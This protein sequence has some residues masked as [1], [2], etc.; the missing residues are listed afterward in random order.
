M[1]D[2][3]FVLVHDACPEAV[4]DV[5]GQC[6]DGPLVLVQRHREIALV[7]QP[8]LLVELLF[9]GCCLVCPVVFQCR[10]A[11]PSAP[12]ETGQGRPSRRRPGLRR[13]RWAASAMVP[14][15]KL[16]PSQESFQPWF[17]RPWSLGRRYSTKP[18]P[19]RSPYFSIHSRAR[20]ACA[21][22][23]W[24]TSSRQPPTAQFAQGGHEKGGRVGGAVVG[25]ASQGQAGSDAEPDLVRDAAGFLF[26][27]DVHFR[28]P[29][30]R[31]GFGACPGRGWG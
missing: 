21:S 25:G 11:R 16:I 20:S 10:V 28:C 24:I 1:T 23:G 15:A 30:C 31:P 6:V 14:S 22:S 27:V 5:G 2:Y 8:E 17:T 29:G 3:G 7:R 19:S 18:S 12:A 26:G 4:A 9:E 13:G